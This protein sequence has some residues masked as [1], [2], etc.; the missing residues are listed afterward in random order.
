LRE[1]EPVFV[2]KR[3]RLADGAKLWQPALEILPNSGRDHAVLLEFV[4]G[5][6]PRNLLRDAA[7][8]NAWLGQ[9]AA[10]M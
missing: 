10:G 2:L 9:V 3:L 8:L 4:A 1:G 5:D 7:T 6:D